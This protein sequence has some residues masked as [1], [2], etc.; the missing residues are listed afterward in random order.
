MK[1]NILEIARLNKAFGGL[2]ATNNIDLGIKEGELS[3]IIGPNGA[4]KTTLFNLIT[5][6]L[7][8]DSGKILFC[9][10][11]I[12]GL[13]PFHVTKTGIGMTFQRANIFP[14]LTVYENVEI[15]VVS[16]KRR[17][18]NLLSSLIEEADIRDEVLEIMDSVNLAGKK[19]VVG[20]SLAHGDQKLLDIGIALGLKPRL[21]LVDE[22]TAGMS[23]E[24]RKLAIELLQK[25]WK[26]MGMTLIF[27]E[28]DMDLVFSI[29]QIIR[30]I[31]HGELIAEGPPESI[32]KNARVI[33]AYLGDEV[34]Y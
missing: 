3:A 9:G 7:K 2:K 22:P 10:K 28:H 11:D 31:H 32:A 12:T 14:R 15:S 13:P 16:R 21:L 17:T 29:S 19:D 8:P 24:E 34:C 20:D 4:G 25:L 5:G 27:I 33:E 30:V 26:E 18:L 23:P 1:A 6:N